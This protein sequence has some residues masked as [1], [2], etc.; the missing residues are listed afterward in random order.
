M[1]PSHDDV[2]PG[3]APAI[4]WAP[5]RRSRET[6]FS[7]ALDLAPH[8]THK[9]LALT[10]DRPR[11]RKALA[12]TAAVATL[13][14]ATF[15]FAW[16][17]P[18][19]IAHPARPIE[20]TGDIT[21]SGQ[22]TGRV[23]GR[24]ILLSVSFES[25][26]VAAYVLARARHETTASRARDRDAFEHTV[27]TEFVAGQ[28]AAVLAA[29]KA[30]GVDPATLHVGFAPRD[31][32]GPSA[33]LVYALALA[34][35]LVPADLARGRTVAVTGQVDG[36]GVVHRVGLINEKV[37][38]ARAAGATLLLVPAGQNPGNVG[39]KVVEV[40]TLTDAI[41]ALLRQ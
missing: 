41:G 2:A 31:L 28:S 11:R 25:P 39:I 1:R 34:D 15:A 37:R 19:L 23:D 14:A 13:A 3:P 20:V 16:H 12:I 29:A 17:L 33:S 24:Y 26:T 27:H 9:P 4:N 10:H 18:I 30:T 21:V 38:A 6:S 7:T 8:P 32:G 36:D 35:M 22:P 40:A 5:S